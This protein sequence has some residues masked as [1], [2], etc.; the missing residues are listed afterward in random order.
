MTEPVQAGPGDDDDEVITIGEEHLDRRVDLEQGMSPVPIVSLLLILIATAV[1][2]L[3]LLHGGDEAHVS[4][5]VSI[6]AKDLG[7][8]QQGEVWRLVSPT[9]LH[10]GVDHLIGNAIAL[11]VL[12]VACEHAFGRVRTLSLFVATAIGGSLLSCLD[13]RPSVGASGAV[14]GLM[15]A[16]ATAVVLRRQDLHV[17]DK[18]VGVVLFFWAAWSLVTGVLDPMIDNFCHLGG[19]VVGC[20]LGAVTRVVIIPWRPAGSP[21]PALVAGGASA[22]ALAWALFAVLARL[23]A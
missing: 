11:Y 16:V 13:A 14:F 9:L 7:S 18:R 20:A 19:F 22:L 4:H 2:V 6:G 3:Q 12:G 21:V 10:G 1:Y 8:I 5:W 23:I 17:R 15:G